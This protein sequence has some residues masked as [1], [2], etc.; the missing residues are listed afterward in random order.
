MGEMDFQRAVVA[1]DDFAG[2]VGLA[3]AR[4]RLAVEAGGGGRTGNPVRGF[5]PQRAR[6]KERTIDALVHVQHV[7][8][9]VLADDVPRRGFET[10]HA[11]YVQAFALAE[12]EIEHARMLTEHVAIGRAHLARARGQVPRKELTEIPL[13]DE[14]DAGGI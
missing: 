10:A 8:R 11:A 12:S 7:V 4:L 13:A 14:A 6:V 1:D 9:D 5:G 3:I 2:L